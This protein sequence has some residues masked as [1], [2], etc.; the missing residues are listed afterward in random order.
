MK[1]KFVTN[2]A[3]IFILNF[4][5]KTFWMFGIDRTVQNRVGAEEYGLYFSL[6]SLSILLNIILDI[7]IT[8][9]NNRSIAQD[10]D[11]LKDQFSRIVP[12]K[13]FLSIIYAI[14]VLGTGMI[15]GYSS[16]QFN[17]LWV[18]VINQFLLSFI[19]YLRSNISG[20][21]L[22]RTDSFLS[23]LDR[24]FV[25]II[26]SFL[27]WTSVLKTEFKIEWFVYAQTVAYL[28][29]GI[30]ILSIVMAKTGKLKLHFPFRYGLSI[31]KQSYPFAILILLMSSFNRFDSVFLERMLEDGK[32]QSGIYAQSFRIL[33]A[34]NMFAFLIA[35][36]LLPIFSRMLKYKEE[37]GGIIKLSF[38]IV[39]IPALSLSVISFFYNE[40]IISLLYND[41]LEISAKVFKVLINGFIFISISYIFGSLLT[42]NG[43]LRQ[44]NIIAFITLIIN[45]SL[46]LLLIPQYKAYGAAIAALISQ[47]FYASAQIIMSIFLLRLKPDFRIILKIVAFILLIAAGSKLIYVLVENWIYG[48]FM[49]ILLALVL[50]WAL[51]ILTLRG[52]FM[53]LKH[54]K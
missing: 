31:L 45:I 34:A 29:A 17:L 24:F 47:A 21:H 40:E 52:L 49:I 32:V 33:D 18:L 13:L 12:L 36:M 10:N 2:F 44:L 35:G 16:R 26:C 3:L 54:D 30:I 23:I 1:R 25:I 19:L 11:L 7:G 38:S 37:V 15:L 6:L 43:N 14:I 48:F 53:I 28:L 51:R 42:A 8:N 4:F 22:F 9:F 20:L 39:I 5:V 27:L 41:H 46:N 50:S